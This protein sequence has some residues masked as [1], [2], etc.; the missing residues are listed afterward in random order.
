MSEKRPDGDFISSLCTVCN[1][2]IGFEFG[3]PL[4]VWDSVKECVIES[5]DEWVHFDCMQERFECPVTKTMC[6]NK[7]SASEPCPVCLA[8]DKTK[9]SA[10]EV[11]KT[12][13]NIGDEPDG[14][15]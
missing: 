7:A 11:S 1:K 15:D 6:F 8:C 2:P 12:I 10:D 3:A 9:S 13:F 4:V 14:A 5:K